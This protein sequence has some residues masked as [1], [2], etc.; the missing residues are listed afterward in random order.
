M[1]VG[2]VIIIFVVRSFIKSGKAQSIYNGGTRPQGAQR[3]PDSKL[4]AMVTYRDADPKFREAE[5]RDRLSNLYIM[6]QNG[7]TK[8]DISALQPYF[9]DALFN[10]YQ[11]QL[12]SF[13][14]SGRTNYVDNIAVLEVRLRGWFTQDEFDHIIVELR[15]RITDYTVDDVT[16]KIV[17]GSKNFEKFMTYEW[18]LSRKSG[19]RTGESNEVRSVSCPHCGAPLSINT[20]AHC[21]Y[22]DSVVTVDHDDWAITGIKGISQQTVSR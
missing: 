9:T 10:Q 11:H 2:I 5:L 16:G 20:T 18:D 7:W 6:M 22:C 13:K 21:P 1:L 14:T 19:V 15:T 12:E 8:K 17:S 3:T 4:K